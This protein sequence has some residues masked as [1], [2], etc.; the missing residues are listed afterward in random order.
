MLVVHPKYLG[1]FICSFLL[2]G[3]ASLVAQLKQLPAN[4]G[5][6]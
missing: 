4:E 5:R 6:V 1:I 3:R 2:E